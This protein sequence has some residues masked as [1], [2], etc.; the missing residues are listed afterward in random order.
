MC[1]CVCVEREREREREREVQQVAYLDDNTTLDEVIKGNS[2]TTR[3]VKLSDQHII[4]PVRQPVTKAC[5]GC[6][7]REGGRG[8]ESYWG[9]HKVAHTCLQLLLVNGTRVIFV[10]A[11]KCSLP[12]VDVL[13]ESP[14]LLEVDGTISVSVKHSNHQSHCLRVEWGPRT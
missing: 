8:R 7:E 6:R 14:E 3:S 2:P 9:S 13:P 12:V 10:I 11:A 4:E 1:V 5:Q